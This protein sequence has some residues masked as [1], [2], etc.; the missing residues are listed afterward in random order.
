MLRYGLGQGGPKVLVGLFL[1]MADGLARGNIK[2]SP[3]PL[4][5]ACGICGQC[6]DCAWHLNE[7]GRLCND[8]YKFTELMLAVDLVINDTV[9]HDPS[10]G[11]VGELGW[12]AIK[13]E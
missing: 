10:G 9:H 5:V 13:P 1:S 11:V 6:I 3:G 4:L 8:L 7:V 12:D 2:I